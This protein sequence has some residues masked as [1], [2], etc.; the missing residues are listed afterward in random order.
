ME[1]LPE[2]CMILLIRDP[3][4]VI[5]SV[6]DAARKGSWLYE[7]WDKGAAKQKQL[8]DNKPDLFVKRRTGIYFQSVT[9]AERAF[10]QHRGPKTLVRYEDL[11]TNTLETMKR[12]YSELGIAADPKDLARVVE[13]HAWENIPKEEKGQGKFH[14]KA[15]PGGWREDLT[16]EQARIVEN[17]TAAF[18]ERF[19]T[20]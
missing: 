8:A 16:P 17:V 12:I 9:N 5:A 1:A 2:S 3:R 15:T 13:K 4:D 6:L 20:G 7:R 11:R 10:N 14:R 18:L 19:Y